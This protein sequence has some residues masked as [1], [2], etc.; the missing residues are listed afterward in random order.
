[1]F[2]AP[3]VEEDVECT[4]LSDKRDLGWAVDEDTLAKN[5]I[6]FKSIYQNFGVGQ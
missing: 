3:Y 5:P 1:M 2:E 6:G 4:D